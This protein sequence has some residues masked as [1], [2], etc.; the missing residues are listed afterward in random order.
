M[1]KAP[2]PTWRRRLG[3]ALWNWAPFVLWLLVIYWMSDQPVVPHPGR[4]IGITDDITD[5][6]GHMLTFA[7]LALLAW[8][9]ARTKPL[10]LRD[11]PRLVSPWLAGLFAMLYAATDEIHQYF[12][13]GRTASVR[14]WLAD[15]AGI[16]IA[17]LLMAWYERRKRGSR[18][19]ARG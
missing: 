10:F 6:G 19:A 3:S 9:V 1:L 8:R 18:V 14:D 11:H 2:S 16:L 5:Y 7:L 17:C 12:V 4:R 15:V 13:P